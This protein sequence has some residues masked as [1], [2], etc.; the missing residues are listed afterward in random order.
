MDTHTRAAPGGLTL[1]V[2]RMRTDDGRILWMRRKDHGYPLVLAMTKA[3]ITIPALAARTRLADPDGRGISYQLVGRLVT[4]DGKSA[5]E[6]TTR[7]SAELIAA[8]LGVPL[9]SVFLEEATASVR[10]PRVSTVR[11]SDSDVAQGAAA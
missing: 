1:M 9:S 5:R 8:A 6:T 3:G 10:T 11:R 2:T 7:R 4:V